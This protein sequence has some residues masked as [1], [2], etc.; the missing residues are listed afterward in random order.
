[1]YSYLFVMQSVHQQTL[2]NAAE[3]PLF[4]SWVIC[5]RLSPL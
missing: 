5:D 3:A 1:M 4:T 2:S